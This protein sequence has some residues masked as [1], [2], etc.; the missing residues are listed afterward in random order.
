MGHMRLQVDCDAAAADTRVAYVGID[1][2]VFNQSGL[3]VGQTGCSLV[4]HSGLHFSPADGS[5]LTAVVGDQHLGPSPP[6]Y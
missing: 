3:T 5:D 4:S 2:A 1:K 6:G